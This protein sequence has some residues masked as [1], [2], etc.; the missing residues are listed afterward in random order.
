MQNLIQLSKTSFTRNKQKHEKL[1]T[2]AI[3]CIKTVTYY[4]KTKKKKKK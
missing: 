2:F 1:L 4:K 3:H